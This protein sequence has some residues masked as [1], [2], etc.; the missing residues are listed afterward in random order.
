MQ[1][2]DA[3]MPSAREASDPLEQQLQDARLLEREELVPKEI[4]PRQG[5]DDLMLVDRLAI[6]LSCWT[7]EQVLETMKALLQTSTGAMV[8]RKSV[9]PEKVPG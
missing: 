1:R 6:E 3:Q 4:E 2:P 8:E 7:A 9:L 5:L